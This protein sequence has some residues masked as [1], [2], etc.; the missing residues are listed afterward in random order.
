LTRARAAAAGA[1]LVALLLAPLGHTDRIGAPRLKPASFSGSTIDITGHGFGHGRG[2]GQYGALGYAVNQGWTYE[3]ILDHFYGGTVTG[4]VP[5][6]QTITVDITARDGQDTIVAQ[7]RGELVTT[8]SVAVGCTS[9][10]P[11]AVLIHRTGSG[12]FSVYRSNSCSGGPSGWTLVAPAVAASNIVVSTTAGTTDVRQD[13]LQLCE[14]GVIRWLRGDLI[15]Q[16][17]GT[18]QATVNRLPIEGYV[19]GVVPRE[20]PAAWGSL[21]GGSGRQALQAQAVASRSYGLAEN[22]WP[23]AKTCDTTAC[24]VYG[25][26]AMQ[27]SDGTFT[28]LEGTPQYAATDGAVAQTAGEVRMLNGAVA[29]TEFSSSTGGYTAGG[30]FPAV[31]DSGDAIAANPNHT[32]NATVGVDTVEAAFGQGMG[33]LESVTAT[34]RNGLGDW[35]GRVQSMALQFASGTVAVTGPHFAA[36]LGLPSDWFTITNNVP[37]GYQVLTADGAVYGFGGASSSPP[38]SS[39]GVQSPAVDLAE[40]P[41]GYWVLT[42]GG[43]VYGFGAV[44]GHGDV[45]SMHLNRPP[46]QIVATP[47]GAGYWI[48][49]GDGGVFSFGDARFFGSTGALRLNAPIVGVAPTPDGGGYWLL[50]ADGGVFSFGDARFFGSTGGMRLNA[51]VNAMASTPDGGGY[52]LAASDGGVFSFGDGEYLGSLPAIHVSGTAVGIGPTASGNGYLIATAAG[53]VYGFGDA[54]A[55]GGPADQHAPASAVGLGITR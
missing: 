22:R 29:R 41:G 46:R 31:V 27:T 11:C 13:M 50:G 3:Q 19:R 2:L 1:A 35:G 24:Q 26:R 18:A 7:E 25:G 14:V 55:S 5:T 44:S 33:A 34:A 20:V 48:I 17:T 9:G 12:S 10:S 36:A 39:R 43:A 30:T 37:T 51:P 15:A 38:L 4:Q 21:G 42:A 8:P 28:D 6:T 47:T 16:D 45:S 32:W 53:H 40:G 52:W 54:T 49:A 23:Y